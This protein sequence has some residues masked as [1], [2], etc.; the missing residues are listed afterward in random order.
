MS[1][2]AAL[3]PPGDGL[4]PSW[5]PLVQTL[6]QR[7]PSSPHLILS[8]GFLVVL[9]CSSH[10]SWDTPAYVYSSKSCSSGQGNPSSHMISFF[11]QICSCW[12][13]NNTQEAIPMDH[14]FLLPS[15][16]FNSSAFLRICFFCPQFLARSSPLP[17]LHLAVSSFTEPSIML[18]YWPNLRSL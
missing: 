14:S 12:W 9:W 4:T 15:T 5:E 13:F 8:D 11:S 6:R 2:D 1:P 16:Y 7:E 3:C 18:N 17:L 10:P